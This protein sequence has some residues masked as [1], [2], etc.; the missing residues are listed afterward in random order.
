MIFVYLWRAKREESPRKTRLGRRE[1]E[2]R[3]VVRAAENCLLMFKYNA[4]EACFILIMSR[5]TSLLA[6]LLLVSLAAAQN[7]T[8]SN[9]VVPGIASGI[10]R[11][12]VPV[13]NVA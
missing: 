1:G 4:E 5:R 9:S 7:F 11:L 8:C 2:K 12:G 13:S 6:L 3:Y 10:V